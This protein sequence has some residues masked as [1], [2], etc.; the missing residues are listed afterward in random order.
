MKNQNT[1][2]IERIKNLVQSKM[3]H[4]IA[5][6]ANVNI[7][8]RLT[9]KA[10]RE[11]LSTATSLLSNLVLIDVNTKEAIFEIRDMHEQA[12]TELYATKK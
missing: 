11:Y 2:T 7:G 9:H 12:L 6:M 8:Q 3:I 10:K 4:D 1:I 5:R